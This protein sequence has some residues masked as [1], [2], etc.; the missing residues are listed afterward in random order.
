MDRG[1]S[2]NAKLDF[3]FTGEAS[4]RIF[5][6]KATQIECGSRSAPPDGC[7]QYHTNLDGRLTTFNYAPMDNLHL[8]DQ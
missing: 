7:L 5:E 3:S 6:I 4:T 1:C 2:G 8:E